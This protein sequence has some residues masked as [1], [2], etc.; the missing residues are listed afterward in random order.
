M[1]HLGRVNPSTGSGS[2][3]LPTP[4]LQQRNFRRG[5]EADGEAAAANTSAGEDL[6]A[7]A[8][9]KTDRIEMT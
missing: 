2:G 7:F 1:P 4:Q 6:A 3:E 9:Y 5:V 8:C